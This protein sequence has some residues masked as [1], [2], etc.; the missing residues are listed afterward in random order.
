MKKWKFQLQ[1][2]REYVSQEL[3]ETII[4]GKGQQNIVLKKSYVF[5]KSCIF[6]NITYENVKGL[7]T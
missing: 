2:T 3:E 6:I 1:G 7:N 5:Y 4:N